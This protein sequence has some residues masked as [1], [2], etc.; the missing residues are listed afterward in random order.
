M[1][2]KQSI[3]RGGLCYT[4]RNNIYIRDHYHSPRYK[5]IISDNGRDGSSPPFQNFPQSEMDNHS[6]YG[7]NDIQN[8]INNWDKNAPQLIGVLLMLPQ[9]IRFGVVLTPH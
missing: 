6:Y 7:S 2:D 9:V 3:Y 4:Y 1:C 5:D 8:N